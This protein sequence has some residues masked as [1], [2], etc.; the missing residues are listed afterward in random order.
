[1]CFTHR[2]SFPIFIKETIVKKTL[3]LLLALGLASSSV[4]AGETGGEFQELYTIVESWATG[5][6]GRAIALIFL[7][8]GLGMGIIRGSVMGAVGCV[9]TAMCLVIAPS[10]IEGILTALI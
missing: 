4:Y 10:V 6:L 8:V 9:A 3:S 5:Y 7:L 1:M 2:A